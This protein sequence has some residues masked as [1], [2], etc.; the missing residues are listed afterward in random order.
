MSYFNPKIYNNQNL[1]EEDRAELE[2]WHEVFE[3]AV[4][5]VKFDNNLIMSNSETLEKIVSEIIADFCTDLKSH[6]DSIMQEH[7]VAY[8]NS[9]DEN[10]E[11]KEIEDYEVFYG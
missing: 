8:I 3:N 7:I 9:Y 11:I 6:I 5:C 4:D 10:K 2:Y 1:K